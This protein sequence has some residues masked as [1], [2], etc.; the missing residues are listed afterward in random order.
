[1]ILPD[2]MQEGSPAAH[3]DSSAEHDK[4]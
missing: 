3:E 1:L 2:H 4:Q